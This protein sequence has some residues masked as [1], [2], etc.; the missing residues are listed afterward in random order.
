MKPRFSRPTSRRQS[1]CVLWPAACA[2]ALGSHVAHAQTTFNWTGGVDGSAFDMFSG[3]TAYQNWD[4]ELTAAAVGTGA[5]NILRI[6]SRIGGGPLAPIGSGNPANPVDTTILGID[7]SS[8]RMGRLVF[9]DASGHFPPT[10]IFSSRSAGTGTTARVI[11]FDQPDTEIIRVENTVTTRVRMGYE[12]DIFGRFSLRLP[13]SGISTIYVGNPAAVLD[14]T[15]AFDNVTGRGAI[16]GGLA[17]QSLAHAKL[18]KTGAGTLDLR[19]TDTQGNPVLG[20]IIEG[21]TVIIS[22]APQLGWNPSVLMPDHIVING[23]TLN[24]VALGTGPGTNRG[25]QVG[26]N[27]GIFQVDG[28]TLISGPVTDV[29]GQAG[30]LVKTGP[31]ALRLVSAANSYSGGSLVQAGILRATTPASFGTGSVSISDGAGISTFGVAAENPAPLLPNAIHVLGSNVIFGDS[32]TALVQNTLRLGGNVDLNGNNVSM[33]IDYNTEMNGVVSNGTIPSITGRNN[34]HSL[35]LNASN[36]FAGPITVERGA[37]IVNG[38]VTAN[39]TINRAVVAPAAVASVGGE[40]TIIGNVVIDGELRPGAAFANAIGTLSVNGNVTLS[41]ASK[42]V[43]EV[44]S[45]VD[46]DQ[47]AATGNV[48]IDGIVEVALINGYDPEVDDSLQL[49]D[50]SGNVSLGP[51]HSLS[52]PFLGASKLWDTSEFATTGAVTVIAGSVTQDTFTWTGSFPGGGTSLTDPSN[53]NQWDPPV[54]AASFE[55]G[56]ANTFNLATKPGDPAVAADYTFTLDASPR[57]GSFFFSDPAGLF[58]ATVNVHANAS[59]TDQRVIWF[60][61]P[62]TTAISLGNDFTSTLRFGGDPL[63]SGPLGFRLPSSGITTFHVANPL[64]TL[65]L[66][67]LSNNDASRGAIH[68][69]STTL[70]QDHARIR[71]TGAGTLDLRYVGD[72]EGTRTLGLTVEGGR[73]L[74][75]GNEQIGWNPPAFMPDHIVLNGG[76]LVFS[77]A[78]NPGANRGI[79]VGENGGRIENTAQVL[80]LDA[81]IQDVP[82]EQ[83]VL[84][85]S[86]AIILRVGNNDN[87]YSGGT[88]IEQGRLRFSSN[89]ALGSGT[90]T[91]LNDTGL[92]QSVAGLNLPNDILI[93]GDSARFNNDGFVQTHSGTIDLNGGLKRIRC[94]GTTQFLGEVTNGGIVLQT[95]LNAQRLELFATNTYDDTTTVDRGRLIVNGAITSDVLVTRAVFDDAAIGALGGGGTVNGN[96][97][98]SGELRPGPNTTDVPGTLTINGELILDSSSAAIFEITGATTHDRVNGLSSADLDGTVTITLLSGYEPEIGASFDLIDSSSPASI[99]SNFSFDLPALPSGRVWD[100]SSF[101]STGVISVIAGSTDPY[102][103]W[104]TSF[105]LVGPDAARSFDFDKDNFTNLQEFLFGGNPTSSTGS[106]TNASSSGSVLTVT[107]LELL[108]GGSYTIQSNNALAG[109]WNPA[110]GITMVNPVDQTGVPAGYVRRQFTTPIATRDFFRVEGVED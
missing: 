94:T 78:T 102:E 10:L 52:L 49:V 99:G 4:P 101:A 104:A 41:S 50:L 87:S 103:T 35:V 25:I 51:N 59:G 6:A 69:G 79:M 100:T 90:V 30:V 72:P 22:S 45:A 44:G 40:G 97:I 82:G 81:L 63:V 75:N 74:I 1:A 108:A 31:S 16:S 109:A 86:G 32:G 66:S 17:T 42:V 56:T 21:G 89:G 34:D 43:F 106:L 14:F 11:F 61:L 18:R 7:G 57:A 29:P 65:D 80:G 53:F 26:Q 24:L 13:D 3:A 8:P 67:G 20:T 39:L 47:I 105:G 83:G 98:I 71:K 48:S 5:N 91:M 93:A 84:I 46:I 92:I 55:F 76:T 12:P 36:T 95:D 88:V 77:Q 62:N 107:Y 27:Q 73:V 19:T 68:A 28:S 96:A 70:S 110:A 9:D 85:K 23:G 60:D 15:G 58:P 33:Q 38:D 37:L 2:L 54:T 64:A